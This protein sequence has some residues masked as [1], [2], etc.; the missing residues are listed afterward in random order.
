MKRIF[1]QII[2]LAFTFNAAIAQLKSQTNECFELTSI[3]FRLAEAPEY[4][5]NQISVYTKD[6]DNYFGKYKKHK[7]IS[8]AKKLRT[9]FGIS[10]DAVIVA[11]AY[12]EVKNGQIITKT[13]T[14]I[15][16]ISK[17]DNRWS[18]QTFKKFVVL[19]NDFYMKTKFRDFYLK[20]VN[21]YN[22]ATERADNLLKEINSKWFESFFGQGLESPLVIVS[23]TNGPNNYG[24]S[25]LE[26]SN[27]KKSGIVIGCNSDA[28][29]LPWYKK[30]M[31][32]IVTHEFLHNYGNIQISNFWNQIDSAAYKIY[33]YT[34][35]EMQRTSYNNAR[36]MM[37]EWFTRL[38]TI[39]YYEENPSPYFSIDF[40]THCDHDL[41]F[42]WMER[43]VIFMK[44]FSQNRKYFNTIDDY[45]PQIIHF[46]NYTA[47]NFEQV[48]HEY[49]NRYPYV[50]DIF[51]APN[52]TVSSDIDTI[53]IRFSEPMFTAT[54]GIHP[55]DDEK[56]EMLPYKMNPS[57]PT[58][59][60]KDKYTF[61][62]QIEKSELKKDK[63]YGFKLNRRFFQSCKTYP[64]KEDYTYILKTAK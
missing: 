52:S 42:L 40:Q 62:I 63:I 39:I 4:V 58:P 36:S 47:N 6:I 27:K 31:S 53:E 11:A 20:H 56:I 29:G 60:W 9:E 16:K 41:G 38:L 32:H 13:S 25:I 45:M 1:L 59:V 17:S 61:I 14:D 24:F 19:I 34:E 44:H 2:F 46:I 22:T 33:S 5:N 48:M 28:E 12:L 8:F 43:S 54:H 18:E 57:M 50:V 23:L 30:E 15:T 21:L 3:V 7:L 26:K 64:M 35:N 55:V 37:F 10:Y 49:N 51:P